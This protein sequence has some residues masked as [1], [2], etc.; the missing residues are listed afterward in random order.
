VVCARR[1]TGDH[2]VEVTGMEIRGIEPNMQAV[3]RERRG[4]LTKCQLLFDGAA[5]VERLPL[6]P[7]ELGGPACPPSKPVTIKTFGRSPGDRIVASSGNPSC[8]IDK[9]RLAG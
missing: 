8:A 5:E 7:L 4:D 1:R 9:A 2:P 6:P 3:G